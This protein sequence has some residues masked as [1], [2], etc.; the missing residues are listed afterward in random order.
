MRPG[1]L[2]LEDSAARLG[3]LK[4]LAKEY[5][6]PVHATDHVRKFVRICETFADYAL[7]IVLD[8]D[9]GGYQMPVSLQDSEGLDG[10]DAVERMPLHE[11]LQKS[12]VLIWSTNHLEAPKM[13]EMLGARGFTQVTRL[14]WADERQAIERRLRE[15][16]AQASDA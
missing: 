12:P 4:D 11:A 10:L 6:V 1:I 15:W 2:V 13:E 7:C 14:A 9:L 3:W 8:H 16:C 5:D